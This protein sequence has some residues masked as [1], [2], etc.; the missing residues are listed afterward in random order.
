MSKNKPNSNAASQKETAATSTAPA[1][2]T[3]KKYGPDNPN[4]ELLKSPAVKLVAIAFGTA[5]SYIVGRMVQG[6]GPQE[7]PLG[8][9]AAGFFLSTSL[10]LFVRSLM[11][12][13]K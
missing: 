2:S 12:K 5:V 7:V 11:K 1:T 9:Y 8:L 6:G 3:A 10:F 13:K 4:E